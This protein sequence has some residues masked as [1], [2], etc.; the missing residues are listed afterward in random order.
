MV[1]VLITGCGGFIGSHLAEFMLERNYNVFGTVFDFDG[2]KNI[3][4]IKDKITII[5]WDMKN[6][7]EAEDII[8]KS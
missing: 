4:H 8:Q 5:N 1:N 6:K 3:D 7:N 2:T